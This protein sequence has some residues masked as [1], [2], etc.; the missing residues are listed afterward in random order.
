MGYA[1][2]ARRRVTEP[3]K[4]LRDG[5]VEVRTA[6]G[7]HGEMPCAPEPEATAQ[8]ELPV[9][10]QPHVRAVGSTG[11][12]GKGHVVCARASVALVAEREKRETLIDS[13]GPPESSLD[14]GTACLIVLYGDELGR[15][16]TLESDAPV[17]FG[18]ATEC[19]V[20]L[21]DETVSRTHARV[22]RQ[23]GVFE[24]EDLGSTNGVFIN[25]VL[26]PKRT[27][28]DGDQV[29]VGRTIYK[30][31]HGGN[32]EADYHEVIYHLM[33]NDGLTLAY[34]RRYFEQQLLGELSR[35][36]RYERPLALLMFDIDHFK[37]VNDTRGHLG[38]DEI[39][40]QLAAAVAQLIRREDV[41][42]RIGGEEFALLIPEGTVAGAGILAERL[43]KMIEDTPFLV[44]AEPV[45]VTCSFG[46]GYLVPDD[47]SK[48]K[49]L[50]ER[51]DSALYAAK[52]AGRN[53]V[54]T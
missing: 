21:D 54:R 11:S 27:L 9:P 49:D 35:A 25:N 15:R 7:P 1:N 31:L 3:G 36:I 43:R 17:T 38:G 4:T 34:N 18:R 14:P 29:K 41:F 42:A 30:F 8:S 24:I 19:Q 51:A 10:P 50:Y 33:T 20:V 52:A 2:Q 48:P 16:I 39:L 13:L 40:R 12:R 45:H 44:E 23:R 5:R 47:R 46:L 32:I 22:T 6:E 53:C 26:A 37:R 28:C